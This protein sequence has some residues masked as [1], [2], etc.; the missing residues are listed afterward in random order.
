MHYS[1][2]EDV[3]VALLAEVSAGLEEGK[4]EIPAMWN[5]SPFRW[6][7][8]LAPATKG[9]MFERLINGYLTQVGF[10]TRKSPD[11]EADLVVRDRRIEIKGSTLWRDNHSYWFEQLRDQDYDFA[12]CLGISPFDAHC[13]AI[14]K[15]ILMNGVG[16]LKG[17]TPQHGGRRATDTAALRVYPRNVQPWLSPYGGTL[18]QAAQVLE[19]L[20]SPK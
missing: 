18:N 15:Y 9:K 4:P 6:I 17:L 13:W 12:V 1:G 5:G 20:T 14:P 2:L 8:D 3:D 19:S 10:A 7:L 16:E 11:R